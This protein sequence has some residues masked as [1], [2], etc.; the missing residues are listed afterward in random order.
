[1]GDGWGAILGGDISRK[2]HLHARSIEFTHPF[3]G[4]QMFFEAPLPDHMQKSFD[5]FGW[6]LKWAPKD[7]FKVF[8]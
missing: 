1:M 2:M 4:K 7:P 3:S 8:E 6:N 5:Y